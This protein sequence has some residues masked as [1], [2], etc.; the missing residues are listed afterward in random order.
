MFVG[1]FHNHGQRIVEGAVDLD[2]LGAIGDG[3]CQLSRCNFSL[4]NEHNG[5]HSSPGRVSCGR[6]GGVAGRCADDGRGTA[7]QASLTAA[8]M[9]RSLKEPVGLSSFILDEEVES[10]AKLADKLAAGIKGVL[11]SSRLTARV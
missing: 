9:P 6:G 11:P 5:F 2:H 10:A 4:R 1:N 7:S 8:V 3:A